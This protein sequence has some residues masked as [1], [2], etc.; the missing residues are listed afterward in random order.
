MAEDILTGP[1]DN[2]GGGGGSEVTSVAGRTGAVTLTAS[3][4]SGVQ[5][6]DSDL[7]AI[8]ALTTTAFGREILTKGT[9]AEIR[10]AIN[11]SRTYVGV[12]GEDL[13][14]IKE[15]TVLQ[16]ITPLGLSIS[17]SA[18]EIWLVKYWLLV[19]FSSGGT[20]S[21]IKFGFT[22]PSGCTM[23][24]GVIN[25][26]N[27]ASGS[28]FTGATSSTAGKILTASETLSLGGGS[29]TTAGYGYPLVGT[30]FGGGTSGTVQI[31]Y[32]QNESKSN[33]IQILKGSIIEAVRVRS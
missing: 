15:Q 26:S 28:W 5:P 25:S 11:V 16:N 3:D 4:V 30:V 13:S 8:A 7:T 32:A 31:Q 2:L 22:A 14:T 18:T 20:E 6:L 9:A 33:T 23:K 24:W 1:S 27:N 21:D 17:A 10:E 12:V 29:G 19:N